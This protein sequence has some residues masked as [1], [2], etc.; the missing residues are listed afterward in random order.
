MQDPFTHQGTSSSPRPRLAFTVSGRP[1]GL[2]AKA[3]ALV[4]ACLLVA[5]GLV[6]SLVVFAVL[7]A[8]VLGFLGLLSWKRWRA[9]REARD[10]VWD[11]PPQ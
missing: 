10:Q 5:V 8:A 1:P 3:V 4:T 2:F 7:I 11:M 6:F 9:K